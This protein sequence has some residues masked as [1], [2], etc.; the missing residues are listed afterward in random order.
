MCKLCTLSEQPTGYSSD[1][2]R[3]T[4]HMGTPKPGPPQASVVGCTVI[5]PVH[6][7]DSRQLP[8]GRK[9]RRLP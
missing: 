8:A 7:S 1:A 5:L 6:K 4:E 3:A 9:N 2:A